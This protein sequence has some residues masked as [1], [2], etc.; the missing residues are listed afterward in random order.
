MT[1]LEENF[2]KLLALTPPIDDDGFTESLMLR[3]PPRRDLLRLRT[4]LLLAFAF[5]GCG[6]VT[7]IPGAR[8]FLAELVSGFANSSLIANLSLLTIAVLAALLVW[9]AVT[10][11]ISDA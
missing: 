4:T 5:V 3:L 11:A 2:E 9:G 6:I 8:H 1:D 7:A 10:A